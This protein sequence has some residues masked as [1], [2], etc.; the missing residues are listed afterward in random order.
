MNGLIWGYPVWQQTRKTCSPQCRRARARKLVKTP[1]HSDWQN[2][3]A[4]DIHGLLCTSAGPWVYDLSMHWALPSLTTM[5]TAPELIKH[6]LVSAHFK[7]SSFVA[8]PSTVS[9]LIS[10]RNPRMSF[11]LFVHMQA[12]LFRLVI[13]VFCELSDLMEDMQR[14]RQV[15][16]QVHWF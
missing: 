2:G 15:R 4:V 8:V 12:R 10:S 6:V 1:P 16:K 13:V 11:C 5:H 14:C 3:A 7:W 9:S